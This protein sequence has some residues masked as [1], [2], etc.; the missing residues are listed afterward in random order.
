[1]I[2]AALRA[3][4]AAA[5]AAQ[6]RLTPAGAVVHRPERRGYVPGLF[7]APAGADAGATARQEGS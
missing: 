6:V 5:S 3:A 7:G 2:D 1:V 4:V